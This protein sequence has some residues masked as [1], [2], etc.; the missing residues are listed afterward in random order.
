MTEQ[1]YNARA[2]DKPDHSECNNGHRSSYS[3]LVYIVDHEILWQE[4]ALSV[5]RYKYLSGRPSLTFCSTNTFVVL[6]S[7]TMHFSSAAL[8]VL[9][10]SSATVAA[11]DVPTNVR[12]FYNKVKAQDRCPNELQGGFHSK[13]D[14]NKGIT[15]T[16]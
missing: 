6:R 5:G 1:I 13:D 7:R 16:L 8:S 12:S 3:G 10:A 4:L 15:S 11:R 2:L 9:F 14:D